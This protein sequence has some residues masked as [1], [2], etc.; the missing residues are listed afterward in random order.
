MRRCLM[1]D[2]NMSTLIDVFE[3]SCKRNASSRSMDRK[4]AS[5]SERI[6]SE[7]IPPEI[8]R[9]LSFP[10]PPLSLLIPSSGRQPAL[11]P[12]GPSRKTDSSFY[13]RFDAFVGRSF[14]PRSRD[15]RRYRALIN[16]NSIELPHRRRCRRC[17]RCRPPDTNNSNCTSSYLCRARKINKLI[18]SHP[19]GV[20]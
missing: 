2:Q 14:T 19:P 8:A 18:V 17:R 1:C 6:L 10:P 9:R 15:C 7:A 4:R 12:I 11:T 3:I 13:D 20:R 5:T 16:W